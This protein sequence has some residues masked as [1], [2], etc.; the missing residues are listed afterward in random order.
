MN[1]FKEVYSTAVACPILAKKSYLESGFITP[2]PWEALIF[3]TIP[4][5][6]SSHT[7]I[8]DY[9]MLKAENAEDMG[10]KLYEMSIWSKER[11]DYIRKENIE[12]IRFMDVS[13]FVNKIE[14]VLNA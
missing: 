10:H 3:G 7:G 8:E 2:R 6:L 9:V 5:G 4:I 14:D 13:N 11:R 12:K 1:D